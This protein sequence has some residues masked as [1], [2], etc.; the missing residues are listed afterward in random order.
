MHY[1]VEVTPFKTTW[2]CSSMIHRNG[3]PAV[4]YK[5]GI[6]EYWF[7]GKEY[8][9]IGYDLLMDDMKK[10][11][12]YEVDE[13]EDS[14]IYRIESEKHREDGP[15]VEWANGSKE[16]WKR[17]KRHREDGPAIEYADG[18]KEWWVNGQRH[19][20]GGPAIEWAN[21]NK[22]WFV[23]NKLHREDGPAVEYANGKKEY[24]IHDEWCFAWYYKL[25]LFLNRLRS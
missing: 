1:R 19:R 22:L 10:N 6:E 9:K 14:T 21:G 23:N 7:L 25:L 5:N 2:K 11:I 3:G 20:I 15:A 12:N 13:T 17:G 16:W 4:I 8:S 24:Y 18:K